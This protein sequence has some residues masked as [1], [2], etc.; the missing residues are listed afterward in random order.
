[1]RTGSWMLV[2]IALAVALALPASAQMMGGMGQGGAMGTQPQMGGQG[3]GQ[4]GGMMGMMGGMMGG[5]MGGHRM[6]DSRGGRA[7]S[8][9]G[10]LISIM[11]EHKQDLGLNPEQER[12]LRD[13]RTEFAK[14]SIRR[15]AEIQ[16]AEIELDSL[17]E[18]DKWDL[19]KIEPKVK[20][21]AT[22]QGDLRLAR[23]KT[24]EA[25]RAVLTAEQLD[26]LK[27]GGHRMR[28]MGDSGM[29]GPGQPM[30]PGGPVGPG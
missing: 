4:G 29:M 26:K 23:I 16:V 17:L 22:L 27:Q 25:G 15:S 30:G 14:E 13:L 1:M 21:I 28:A 8:H 7:L 2:T 3:G 18:Q 19:A 20:Q 11:L 6:G 10:P 12:K 24:L 9:E 5:G